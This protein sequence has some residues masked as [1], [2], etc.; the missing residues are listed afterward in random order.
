[1][2]K[3]DQEYEFEKKKSKKSPDARLKS[4]QDKTHRQ[5]DINSRKRSAGTDGADSKGKKKKPLSK[6]ARRKRRRRRIMFAIE[7]V[8]LVIVLAALFVISKW[9]LIEKASFN[10]Q[11]VQVNEL[12]ASV[13]ESME[14]YRTIAVFGLDTRDS[15]SM[16][17]RSDVIMIININNETGDINLVSV[18]RDTYWNVPDITTGNDDKYG[19]ANNAY[20]TGGAEGALNAL[21]KNLDLNITEYVSVNWLG[22][23]LA[24]DY[25]GGVYVDITSDI[26]YYI[27][28]YITETVNSTG[29]GS[30]QLT[31]TGY[32]HLDGIQTV[33]YCRI[34]YT[35]GGD[36]SRTDR[37]REVLAQLLQNAKSASASDLLEAVDVV[38]PEVETNLTLAD[39]ISLV[40]A[41]SSYDIVSSSSF[42]YQ[43][44]TTSVSGASVVVPLGLTEEV[45][46][47]HLELF[48]D[49]EYTPSTTV[50]TISDT[51]ESVTG[52][53]ADDRT[54]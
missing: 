5:E 29:R 44:A 7:A 19:K 35:S 37:Q 42:P 9:D 8:A 41:I 25:L 36:E 39:V 21:N 43:Y 13:E 50:Q 26:L 20:Y 11:D 32:Q 6:K 52:Y 4:E 38:F 47:L 33:A 49:S 14:G 15:D 28:G 53:G 18:M 48:G 23:A 3:K 27:N 34:R 10:K 24:V 16:T 1:M 30:T 12:S 45:A 51:I 54:D 17:G 2:S 46:Q 22:V 31:S 40:S